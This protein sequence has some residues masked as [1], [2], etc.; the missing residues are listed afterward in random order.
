LEKDLEKIKKS[1]GTLIPATVPSKFASLY[2]ERLRALTTP[3]Y[4]VPVILAADHKLEH[5]ASDFFCP[6]K[7]TL[8]CSPSPKHFLFL[9]KE[10]G[11]KV[12][13]TQFGIINRYAKDFPELSYVVKMNSKTNSVDDS[14]REPFSAV[15]TGFSEIATLI[16]KGVKI[17]ATGATLFL[18][19]ER[20]DENLS[21]VS[22]IIA[23]SQR[24][25]LPTVLW[26]YFRGKNLRNMD[27]V[28]ELIAATGVASVL[29]A[30]IVKLKVPERLVKSG[31]LDPALSKAVRDSAGETKIFAAGG[32][33]KEEGYFKKF[34]TFC[35]SELGI[36]GFIMGRNLFQR[37]NLNKA[38]EL[39][40]ELASFK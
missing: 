6:A 13:A 23:K 12:V 39:L 17:V 20:E 37:Q 29:G 34:A 22:K 38:K 19:T 1:N 14:R 3:I 40:S 5:L 11:I 36:D 31:K 28:E 4:A 27:P 8:L 21:Q 10:I 9:A 15:I 25:G 30:E 26:T 24:L 35:L 2:A 18:G 32:S 16:S 33:L 7:Q